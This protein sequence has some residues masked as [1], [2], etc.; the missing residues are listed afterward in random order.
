MRQDKV[1]SYVRGAPDSRNI[2]SIK[3]EVAISK[4]MAMFT[5]SLLLAYLSDCG[6]NPKRTYE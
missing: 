5:D 4:L 6:V 2:T 1:E 3:S